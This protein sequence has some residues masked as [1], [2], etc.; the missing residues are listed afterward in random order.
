LTIFP[1]TKFL[2]ASISIPLKLPALKAT[3]RKVQK[4]NSYTSDAMEFEA[5]SNLESLE[6]PAQPT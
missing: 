1:A 4:L 3:V 5:A 2:A 6:N